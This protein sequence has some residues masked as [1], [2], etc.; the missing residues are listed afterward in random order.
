MN[1]AK[2]GF[3]LFGINTYVVYDPVEK[4][5]AVIDPGMILPEER[6]AMD[7]FLEKNHLELTHIIDTHLHIDHA[8]GVKYLKDKY[9]APF[10]AHEGDRM[11]GERLKSQA[12]QFGIPGEIEDGVV[13]D[14]PLA[15]GDTI[16]I[17]SGELKVLHVPGHSQG[18][19]ALYDP[20]AGFVITGDALFQGSVGRTDLPGG[21]GRQLIESIKTK[22]LPLPD[23]TVVYPGH[24]PHTTI[25][26]EKKANP[27]LRPTSPYRLY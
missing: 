15:D 21:N 19:V 11:L 2:F 13:I 16:R 14:H 6:E 8:I 26:S 7:R 9:N 22:L 24:G 18:S 23:N 17:G 5:A 27:F 1:I 12:Q 3:S 20:A 10:Y 4:R 25:G